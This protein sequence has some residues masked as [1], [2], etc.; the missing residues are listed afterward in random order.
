VPFLIDW[1]T[2]PHPAA[3]VPRGVLLAGL[4]AEHPEPGRVRRLLGAVGIGLPVEQGSSPALVA[5]LATPLGQIE[6]R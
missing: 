2:G 3:T 6:I 4:R 5:T 1:G